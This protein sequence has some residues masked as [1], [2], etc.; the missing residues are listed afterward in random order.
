MTNSLLA[1]IVTRTMIKPILANYI[2]IICFKTFTQPWIK[3][4]IS[5]KVYISIPIF[6][7]SRTVHRLSKSASRNLPHSPITYLVRGLCTRN[8]IG[9]EM[10]MKKMQEG[11]MGKKKKKETLPNWWR[12]IIN[13]VHIPV[14][15]NKKK[16]R[17]K[18]KIKIES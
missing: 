9:G 6:Y 15:L 12:P 7:N 13:T 14:G 10:K 8:Y 11:K 1:F 3:N 2:L 4:V 5:N 18:N 17:W 16:K